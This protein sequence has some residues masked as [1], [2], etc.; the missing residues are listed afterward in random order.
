MVYVWCIYLCIYFNLCIFVISAVHYS[1]PVLILHTALNRTIRLPCYARYTGP[2]RI[3]DVYIN[4]ASPYYLI[5]MLFYTLYYAI[6]TGPHRVLQAAESAR[7]IHPPATRRCRCRY[8]ILY[9]YIPLYHYIYIPY[10]L[11]TYFCTL[12]TVY[13]C[14]ILILHII[15][16]YIIHYTIHYI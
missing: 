8:T 14:T 15:L 9:T 13:S 10:I 2:Y 4:Y 6:Y 12:F 5:L 11:Y 16:Y 7:P 1:Y 3:F